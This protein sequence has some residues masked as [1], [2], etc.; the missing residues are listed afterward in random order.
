MLTT[1]LLLTLF[2]ADPA[3]AD[4]AS[5]PANFKAYFERAE[6]TWLINIKSREDAIE[7][8]EVAHRGAAA[9]QKAAQRRK[10]NDMKADLADMKKDKPRALL[11]NSPQPGDIGITSSAHVYAVL[12]DKTLAVKAATHQGSV[13]A[14]M[15]LDSTKGIKTTTAKEQKPYHPHDVV[16]VTSAPSDDDREKAAKFMPIAASASLIVLEAIKPTE[17]VKMRTLYDAGK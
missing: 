13:W 2:T 5:V 17:L 15:K 10:I 7:R 4:A 8:A 12:D 1:V 6:A 16:F 9:N 11:P 3:V 14:I